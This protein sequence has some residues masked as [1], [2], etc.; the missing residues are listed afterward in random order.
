LPEL[1]TVSATTTFEGPESEVKEEHRR[2]KQISLATKLPV[3]NPSELKGEAATDLS[4]VQ[5]TSPTLSTSFPLV[6]EGKGEG[7]CCEL[8]A[9]NFLLDDPLLKWSI[10]EVVGI[11]MGSLGI[12][13][14]RLDR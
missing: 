2:N 1:G 6:V 7:P 8:A 10:A 14:G 4:T 13:G 9:K 3:A 12:G 11:S 5:H